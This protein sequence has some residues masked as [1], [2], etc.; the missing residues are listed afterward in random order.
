MAARHRITQLSG[1]AN[2]AG[3]TT[4]PA[5]VERPTSSPATAA[6]GHTEWC[7]GHRKRNSGRKLGTLR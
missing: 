3:N 5:L 2:A 7:R 1:E 6:R 4:S